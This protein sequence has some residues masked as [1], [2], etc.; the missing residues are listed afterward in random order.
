[1][2]QT[3]ALPGHQ[4]HPGSHVVVV[5]GDSKGGAQAWEVFKDPRE[6]LR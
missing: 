5:S 4:H 2:C 1:M 3:S 6:V